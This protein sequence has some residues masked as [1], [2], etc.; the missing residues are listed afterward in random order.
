MGMSVTGFMDIA[1]SRQLLR[2][3]LRAI[4][5]ACLNTDDRPGF[6]ACVYES[7]KQA[8]F[9]F[10]FHRLPDRFTQLRTVFMY[11]LFAYLILQGKGRIILIPFQQSFAD[12]LP[13]LIRKAAAQ[14]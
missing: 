13:E 11:L 6:P 1:Q 5:Y 8:F 9:R 3:L 14:S 7:V 10:P 4:E 2:V 12:V